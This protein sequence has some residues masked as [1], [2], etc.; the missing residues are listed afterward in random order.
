MRT[1]LLSL[2]PDVFDNVA[3]GN[4]IYEHRKVFPDELIK[5]YVFVN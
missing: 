5:A 3:S 2:R 1:M 4:K